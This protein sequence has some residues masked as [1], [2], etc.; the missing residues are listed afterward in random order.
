M[1]NHNGQEHKD[2]DASAIDIQASC[3]DV[4]QHTGVHISIFVL[5]YVAGIRD[6]LAMPICYKDNSY[7]CANIGGKWEPVGHVVQT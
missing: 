4:V 5:R 6:P 7:C 2:L 3:R 1:P